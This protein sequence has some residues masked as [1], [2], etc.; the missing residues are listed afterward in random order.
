MWLLQ[1][2]FVT[3]QPFL[4]I[5]QT[6]DSDGEAM[7]PGQDVDDEAAGSG[8]G[9]AQQTQQK[10]TGELPITEEQQVHSA[11][12][13]LIDNAYVEE[14]ERL[15]AGNGRTAATL[16]EHLE[17]LFA[18]STESASRQK[19][20]DWLMYCKIVHPQLGNNLVPLEQ[21]AWPPSCDV[22][23]RYL[24]A[25]RQQVSSYHRFRRVLGNVCEVANRFWAGKL[26]KLLQ[27]LD[28]RRL[29]EL[30]HQRTLCVIRREHGSSVQQVDPITMHEARNATHFADI[31]SIKGVTKAAAFSMGALL[32]GRRPRTLTEIRWEDL[33][34]RV[35]TAEVAGQT[36]KV[37][38]LKV[39][40]TDEK[41]Q[42]LQGP[43]QASDVPHAEGYEQQF[44]SSPAFWVY[45]QLVMRGCFGSF[46]PIVQAAVGDVLPV[47]A[48]CSKYFLFCDVTANY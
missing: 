40:F 18:T 28:P 38:S 1:A 6:A 33:E 42:D 12:Q 10:S 43:R 29:Y 32:G 4:L 25:M 15:L 45:R 23:T 44:W 24:L 16:K 17:Q 8:D 30:Q 41:F 39:T 19:Q 37:P 13:S 34:L 21:I 20:G 27:D 46:D 2:T 35:A 22:W 5:C 3:T 11:M 14:V 31:L 9:V 26:C 36:I 7:R 47:K 48:E